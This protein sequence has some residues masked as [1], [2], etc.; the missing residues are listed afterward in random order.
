MQSHFINKALDHVFTIREFIQ[1]SEYIIDMTLFDELWPALFD[2]QMFYVTDRFIEWLG[3]NKDS[4]NEFMKSLPNDPT[5]QHYLCS[6]TQ[7]NSFNK[8]QK[9]VLPQPTQ[10]K[11]THL[12][13]SSNCL[14][15]ILMRLDTARGD[16]VRKHYTN[17]VNLAM[18]YLRYL[19][20]FAAIRQARNIIGSINEKSE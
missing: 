14:R 20:Q 9:N 17:I 13:I 11:N 3:Y 18:I 10:N 5:L 6:T 4:R 7:Y 8:K 16:V 19:G 12:L 1:A 2:G 15:D